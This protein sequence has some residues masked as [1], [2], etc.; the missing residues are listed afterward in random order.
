M[1]GVARDGGHFACRS[2]RVL[3]TVEAGPDDLVSVLGHYD[4]R[5]QSPFAVIACS[6]SWVAALAASRPDWPANVRSV[7]PD[8]DVVARLM[9]KVE[10][11]EFTARH[12]IPAPKTVVITDE[13]AAGVTGQ[14][15]GFPAVV[16]P[17]RKPVH[18]DQWMGGKVSVVRDATEL[19]A[20]VQRGLKQ[21]ES[22]IVQEWV[23]G[24]EGNLISFNGYFDRHSQALAAFTARKLRQ[25]PPGAGTSASGEEIRDDEVANLAIEAFQKAGFQGLAYLE[26]KRRYPDGDLMVL[27]A[28]VGRPTG[29]SAICEGGGVE[30]VYSAYRDALGL[31]PLAGN[32]QTQQGVK[33]VYLRH[34]VQ[35]AVV[36]IRQR[37]LTVGEWLRSLRGPKVYAVWSW[38]DPLPFLLDIA[39]A[40]GRAM[41]GRVVRRRRPSQ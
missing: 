41:G 3:E 2:R 38:R 35:A 27:E 40:L 17:N 21:A 16:K 24:G 8:S 22:L 12:G 31:A 5:F 26:V 34:D 23:G 39:Q 32:D 14:E 25:W 36:A 20:V 11:A 19:R 33:W 37:R 4:D 18:W 9:D 6:D 7:V 30:L 29:R 15:I 28:N 13:A 10:F 1:A